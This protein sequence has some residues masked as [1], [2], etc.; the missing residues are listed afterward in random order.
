MDNIE[1]I[2]IKSIGPLSEFPFTN[3]NPRDATE[4]RFSIP[5]VSACAR[6]EIKTLKWYDQK[7]INNGR[8]QNFAK[9]IN[10]ENDNQA[11]NIF[12]DDSNK[13]LSKITIIQK[14]K[15]KF[16][17]E[18]LVLRGNNLTFIDKE[19]LK[20][21]F[22]QLASPIFANSKKINSLTQSIMGLEKIKNIAEWMKEFSP[23]Q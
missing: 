11:N 7:N 2:I 4:G 13:I 16:Y 5:F 3:T 19:Y 21:K 23:V 20:D 1:K 6:Y 14:N 18:E 10:I 12:Q 8:L 17:C 9:K 22:F 15:K